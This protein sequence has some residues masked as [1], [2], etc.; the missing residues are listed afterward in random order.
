MKN[1]ENFGI[2]EYFEN[3]EILKNLKSSKPEDLK[4]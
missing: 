2:L 3:E 4:N 1:T